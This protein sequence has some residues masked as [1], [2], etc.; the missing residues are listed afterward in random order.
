MGVEECV[1]EWL[2]QPDKPV[3]LLLG[4]FGSGKT[5]LTYV[6]AR[7]LAAEFRQSPD[8]SWIPLRLPL[9]DYRLVENS[10]QFLVRRLEEFG[11]NFDGWREL[12]DRG[13]LLT[14]LDGFDEMSIELDPISVTSNIKR[15]IACFKEFD[16]TKIIITSRSHFFE[17]QQYKRRLLERLANP[18]LLRVTPIPRQEITR[19]LQRYAV[20]PNAASALARLHDMHDPI[21]LASKPLFLQMVKETL[22]K[23]PENPDVVSLYEVYARE[24]LGRKIEFLEDRDLSIS[25]SEIVENM[26]RILEDIALKLQRSGARA[27]PMRGLGDGESLSRMLWQMAGSA[28]NGLTSSNRDEADARLRVGIRSLLTRVQSPDIQQDDWPVDFCHR[29]MKEYF[30]ARAICRQLAE[31]WE[32]G[33]DLLKQLPLNHEVLDFTAHVMQ[34][35]AALWI[36]R[37]SRLVAESTPDRNPGRL[38][39]HALTLLYRIGRFIP[40]GD[41]SDRV[42]DGVD[43]SGANL[44][45]KVFA[46]SSLR[47]ANLDNVNVEDADL[48]RC[49]L[50]G[51]RIDETARVSALAANGD[52]SSI[53]VAYADQTIRQ[54]I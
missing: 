21:G 10:R 9:K 17:N 30:V 42:L 49:D 53:L 41:Y 46:G 13:R 26:L 2:A 5:F 3:L 39:G 25:Q 37:L 54:R 35:D 20:T 1:R 51:V 7:A 14:I 19:H 44:S 31:D 15:L 23:L 11:A 36:R 6:I 48:S 43:L 18:T 32:V 40:D 45:G 50:T 52:G 47:G 4:D 16:R 28:A 27:V 8:K 22:D 12:R 24:S 38:G 34:R 29:S 33:A